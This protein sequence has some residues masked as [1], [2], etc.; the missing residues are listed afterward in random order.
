MLLF[1]HFTLIDV[2]Y[3]FFFLFETVITSFKKRSTKDHKGGETHSL[4]TIP[5][6]PGGVSSTHVESMTWV[7]ANLAST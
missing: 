6:I 4:L 3:I 5:P 1:T 2:A 7:V